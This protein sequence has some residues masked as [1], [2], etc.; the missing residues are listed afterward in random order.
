MMPFATYNDVYEYV[1]DVNADYST[2]P[3]ITIIT[4]SPMMLEQK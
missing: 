4:W 1:I 3:I 2:V